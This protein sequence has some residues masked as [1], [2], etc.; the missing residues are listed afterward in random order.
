MLHHLLLIA[1]SIFSQAIGQTE[2]IPQGVLRLVEQANSKARV[3]YCGAISTKNLC[4]HLFVVSCEE[5][6]GVVLVRNSLGDLPII[7]DADTSLSFSRIE[8]SYALGKAAETA[9]ADLLERRNLKRQAQAPLRQ[10]CPSREVSSIG[11]DIDRVIFP[12]TGFKLGSESTHEIMNILRTTHT[13]S[14]EPANAPPGAIIISPT[15]FSP[16]G[17][18]SIGH[19]GIV[20]SDGSIYSADARY[21]GAWVRNFTLASWLNRFSTSNGTY[22]FLLRDR[23]HPRKF[24][25]AEALRDSL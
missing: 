13:I 4:Y 21:G 2:E 8:I 20:G 25:R 11:R 24:S 10:T 15:R 22:A 3:E 18:V 7:V 12:I 1:V 16:H 19:A 17:P 5:L 23:P 9:I 6:A 14:M